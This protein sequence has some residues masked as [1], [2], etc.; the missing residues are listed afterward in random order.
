M[1]T[2]ITCVTPHP[3][4]KQAT[5]QSRPRAKNWFADCPPTENKFPR[6]SEKLL[7]N[8][9][10]AR[11]NLRGLS[12]HREYCSLMFRQLKTMFADR[13]PNS[14]KGDIFNFI[15]RILLTSGYKRSI[16]VS[17]KLCCSI[18]CAVLRHNSPRVTIRAAIRSNFTFNMSIIRSQIFAVFECSD[19]FGGLFLSPFPAVLRNLIGP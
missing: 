2:N 17:Y 8:R 9:L 12:A 1:L 14:S 5:I 3:S 11:R 16:L 13:P 18:L 19:K 6:S 10:R 4:S 15:H 7:S